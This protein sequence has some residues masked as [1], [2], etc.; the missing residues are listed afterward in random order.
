MKVLYR[1]KSEDAANLWLG[2]VRGALNGAESC[3][4]VEVVLQ[5]RNVKIIDLNGNIISEEDKAEY[6]VVSRAPQQQTLINT[7]EEQTDEE[8]EA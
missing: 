5:R 2:E 6:M 3:P 8:V 1:C 7:T 4:K